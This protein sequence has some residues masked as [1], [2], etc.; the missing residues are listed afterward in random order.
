MKKYVNPI[1][2]YSEKRNTSDPFVV[3]HGGKYYHCYANEE[4]VFLSSSERL[5]EIGLAPAR[6]IYD[7]QKEGALQNWYA[8][9]LHFIN[10][11]WYVYAAPDYGDNLHVMTVLARYDDDPMGDYTLVG[12]V[13]GLENEWSIDGT[14]F[15]Y[16]G[17]RWFSWTNCSEI[18][19]AEMR[20][21]TELCEKRIVLSCPEYAFEKCG[22]AVNE[23]SAALIKDGKLYLVYSASDS[24]DDGYCLGLLE[25]LGST[26]E[27]MLDERKWRKRPYPV[28]EGTDE[29]FGPGHCSFTKVTEDGVEKDYIVYHA[30]VQ[31]GTGWNG[32]SVWIQEFCFDE[33]GFPVF[34]KP[35][36]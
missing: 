30:N 17:K 21:P 13:K 22:S 16:Q 25:F 31:S 24:R 7:S 12:A 19:L 23:G 20:S 36:K 33:N 29:V 14:P 3:L 15:F 18:Y 9:E 35:E 26:A 10:G 2:P 4:G 11:A 34:G 5:W 1:I 27:E 8:P 6:K 28:F 32:R